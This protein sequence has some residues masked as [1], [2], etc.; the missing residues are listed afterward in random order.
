MV[1]Y[2]HLH[3]RLCQV[4]R[5]VHHINQLYLPPFVIYDRWSDS[6][7]LKSAIVNSS[8]WNYFTT[9]F[10]TELL[11][12][13]YYRAI[14]NCMPYNFMQCGP[15][16]NILGKYIC[17]SCDPKILQFH[18]STTTTSACLHLHHS[19]FLVWYA[20]AVLDHVLGCVGSEGLGLCAFLEDE[21]MKNDIRSAVTLIL[22][23]GKNH[24]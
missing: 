20:I 6:V 1:K 16:I 2:R 21:D 3:A 7:F 17:V 4:M 15:P 5:R 19:F 23:I 8:L 12:T 13:F 10:T 18:S 24:T 22:F 9:Y 14:Q 11:H